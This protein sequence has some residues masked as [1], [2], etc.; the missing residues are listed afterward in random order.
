MIDVKPASE[1]GFLSGILGDADP[2]LIGITLTL[3]CISMLTLLT[4]LRL[5]TA[6]QGEAGQ[7]EYEYE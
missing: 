6:R 2:W 1:E 4:W 5:A 7:W 3:I